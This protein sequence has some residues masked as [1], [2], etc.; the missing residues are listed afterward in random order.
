MKK[1]KT[2]LTLAIILP[3]ILIGSGAIIAS[4][5]TAY[6]TVYYTDDYPEIYKNQ[7]QTIFG[8]NYLLGEKE[9]ITIEGEDCSCGYHS[10]SYEYNQWKISYQDQ[11]GQ[12]FTQTLNNTASLESQQLSWLCRQLAQYYQQKYVINFF[13]EG[14]LKDLPTDE[15]TGKTL[16]YINIGNPVSS[17][18]NDQKEEYERIQEAG[19]EYHGQLLA[20]LQNEDTI[21][22]LTEIDYG[23]IFNRFPIEVTFFLNINNE[24]L[25][26]AEK[27]DFEKGVQ[28]RILEM[29][30]AF[31][32]DTNNACNLRIQANSKNGNF[33]DGSKDWRYFILQGEQIIPE[34]TFDGFEWQFFYAFEGIYW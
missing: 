23:N 1:K 22:R 27:T 10:D 18:T 7:L 28:K 12:T 21:L 24:T 20:Q 8:E 14:T 3:I 11:Y 16:C 26:E 4:R 9:T 15:T 13:D 33:Y 31:K 19:K 30:Q 25:A 5:R 32:Q 2:L 34:N 17:Y 6:E 29:I